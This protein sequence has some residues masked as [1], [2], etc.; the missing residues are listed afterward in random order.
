M[1]VLDSSSITQA[2]GEIFRLERQAD[3]LRSQILRAPAE[4]TLDAITK[5]V[6]TARAEREDLQ[7]SM[8]LMSIVSILSHLNG[9]SVI[10][11]LMDILGDE[12]PETRHAAGTVLYQAAH[13]RFKDVALGVERALDRLPVDSPALCELPYIL[14]EIPEP[15]VVKLLSRFLRHSS[16]EV[17]ASALEASLEVGDPSLA[18]TIATLEKDART[19]ELEPED[20]GE[21]CHGGCD[22]EADCHEHAHDE[23]GAGDEHECC[24]GGDGAEASQAPVMVT[25]GEL[26]REA[27]QLL[28]PAAH[29][30]ERTAHRGHG[31]GGSPSNGAAPKP[32]QAQPHDRGGRKRR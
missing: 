25:I 17:V 9:P 19:V 2:L 4:A 3:E 8:R 5:A 1:S 32:G 16:A 26:A 29:A 22:C 7:R 14:M 27:R 6:A 24:H 28:V 20:D 11:L 15:G 10:D 30:A 18:G 13:E 23:S 12:E 31:G 21:C